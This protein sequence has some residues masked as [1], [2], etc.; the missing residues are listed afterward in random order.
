[1]T[2]W[3]FAGM[4]I[5]LWLPFLLAIAADMYKL[6]IRESLIE[7]LKYS[8]EDD[9]EDQDEEES[10]GDKIYRGINKKFVILSPICWIVSAIIN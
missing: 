6:G 7:F 1:M 10:L 2:T 5:A 9:D 8:S 3:F 4:T